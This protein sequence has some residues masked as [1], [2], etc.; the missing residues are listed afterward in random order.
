MLRAKVLYIEHDAFGDGFRTGNAFESKFNEWL[1]DA[2][3]IK[4]EVVTLLDKYVLVL[5][6]DVTTQPAKTKAVVCTQCR[7][8]PP[9]DGLKV[10]EECR[11]YQADYRKK[12]KDEKKV[13]YP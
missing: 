13:R 4:I 1:V 6:S 2:G 12:R 3:A 11:T 9:V 8:N 10:C 7:K 5:Y